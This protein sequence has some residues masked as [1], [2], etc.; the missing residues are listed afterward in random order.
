MFSWSA[1]RSTSPRNSEPRSRSRSLSSV[2]TP[3]GEDNPEL[4]HF[5]EDGP[6]PEDMARA[7]GSNSRE[8]SP[9]AG[10]E[11]KEVDQEGTVTP[12]ALEG[13]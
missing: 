1:E 12:G 13:G 9:R 11:L 10:L 5:E 3:P 7:T 6:D 4:L 2:H 8:A